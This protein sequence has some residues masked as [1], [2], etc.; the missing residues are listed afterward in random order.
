VKLLCCVSSSDSK[1]LVYEYIENGSLDR[2]LHSRRRA[3]GP[4]NIRG[5]SGRSVVLDW[6]AR[7]A[8]AIGVAKGL[9]YMHHDCSPPV[10]H[11][12]IKSSN[13]LLDLEFNAK[14]A[15]F[16]LA[17][18]LVKS[19]DSVSVVAGSIGYIAPGKIFQPCSRLFL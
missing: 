19:G 12:D 18:M 11:R 2:W 13:I 10:V 14:I 15:D 3:D 5:G 6:P 17:R 16:G 1:L 4:P 9:C 8:I 7:L